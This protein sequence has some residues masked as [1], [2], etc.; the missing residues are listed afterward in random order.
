M[1]PPDGLAPGP[2]S[3]DR[4]ARDAL[5]E[6]QLVIA[7]ASTLDLH[8]I[9][10]RILAED[11]VRLRRS[12]ERRRYTGPQRA[13]RVD[14]NPHQIEAVIFA[15]SRLSEGGCIL[16][17]EV[18]LGKT[19]EAGLV[20]AQRLAEGARRILLLAPKPLLG[21][22]RQELA[23]LFGIDT[24][25]G[26]P[27]PGGFD[28]DGVFLVGRE[29]ATS[30]KGHAALIKAA[31]FDLLIV[32][33]AHE[34]F[35]GLHERFAKSTGEYR[36]DARPAQ[37]AGRLFE[38]LRRTDA[39][40]LL[41]TAT[42]IQNK[43]TELWSLVQYVDRTGTLLG[44]LP[45]FR[46][47]FC[48]DAH[49]RTPSE[50]QGGELRRRLR[51]VVQRTLRR[52]AQE[53]LARPFVDRQARTFEYPMSSEER[54]LYDDVTAYLLDPNIAAFRGNQRRLLLLGFH[55]RMGSSKR[56][57][58]ASLDGVAHR[59][60]RM[61]AG[62]RVHVPGTGDNLEDPALREALDDLEEHI[63]D[64]REKTPDNPEESPRPPT[65][66][67]L[68]AELARVEGFV[69]RAREIRVDAKLTAL[70]RAIRL[71]IERAEQGDGSG[72]IVIFTESRVTQT[73]LCEQLVEGGRYT[74]DDITLFRGTNDSARAREALQRWR[75]ETQQDVPRAQQPSP[76]IAVR[77]ALVHEFKTRTKVFIS[78]EAGAKGLNLQFCETIINYDL[79]WN[80]QRI[81]QRIGRCHRYGQTHAV[82]VINFIS[83]DNE[84]ERLTYEILSQK[85]D[86]F[87]TILDASDQVLHRPGRQASDALVSAIGPEFEA[88][89]RKIHER[90]RTQEEVVAEIRRLRDEITERRSRFKNT[91]ERTA[92]LIESHLDDDVRRIFRQRQKTVAQTLCELDVELRRIAFA[93]LR[94]K[95]V[96]FSVSKLRGGAELLQVDAHAGLPGDLRE[97][98]TVAIGASDEHRSLHAGHPL[99]KAAVEEARASSSSCS[100]VEVRVGTEMSERVQGLR[101]LKARCCLLWVR[102]AGIELVD[103]MIPIVVLEGKDQALPED[104]TAELLSAPMHDAAPS[105]EGPA[106]DDDPFDDAVEE[107][108]FRSGQVLDNQEREAYRRKA[109]QVERS[110]DDRARVLKRRLAELAARLDAATEARDRATGSEAR[111]D[112]GQRLI[113]VEHEVEGLASQLEAI[114]QR[115]D[116]GYQQLRSRNLKRRYVEPTPTRLFD[117]ELRVK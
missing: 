10:R 95:G 44:P 102:Y 60:Q 75:E 94:A 41:L 15:L 96:P 49:D 30:A 7:P 91:Q 46:N 93:F 86:L 55:R 64:E 65:P 43:L 45:V 81:E 2:G 74:L 34:K 90:A 1:T 68:R 50:G 48:D 9:Q 78:T 37:M 101:G 85:L 77:A 4:Q 36:S 8:A 38:T 103:H 32:D 109:E 72:K 98:V 26:Q 79:P 67:E 83:N 57:L 61:I 69:R 62:E 104:L 114:E 47:L 22:W 111:R 84:A 19:I 29:A 80:P 40:V 3:L 59:L 23:D 97:G 76:D 105:P 110:M 31:E 66:E 73:Y 27:K 92:S 35:A 28:G 18:G 99:I 107:A 25:E 12:N 5:R 71:I 20:V 24:I 108:L 42:P 16:A 52:Q 11:L 51:S 87:G 100:A 58:A 54:G 39:P 13:G 53:F 70:F 117:V 113:R 89:L 112:A 88:E 21:Q 106:I 14:A 6:G 115:E 33:E 56:A 82:T 17:D 63:E 116:E